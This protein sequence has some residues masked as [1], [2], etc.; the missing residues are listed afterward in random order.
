MIEH[1]R[2]AGVRHLSS[3]VVGPAM[4]LAIYWIAAG[5]GIRMR[6]PEEDHHV[7]QVIDQTS[8]A[9]SSLALMSLR[10]AEQLEQ[11]VTATVRDV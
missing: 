10:S 5:I 2:A 8:R 11:Q 6:V 1:A 7:G 3:G 4:G 9:S